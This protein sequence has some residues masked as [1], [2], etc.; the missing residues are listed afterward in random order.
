MTFRAGDILDGRFRL[1]KQLGAGSFGTVFAATQLV[2]GHPFRRVAVKI[3]M[4][5][6]AVTTTPHEE[7]R[8]AERFKDVL[9]LGRVLADAGGK[10][11][12]QN[13][14]EIY[15]LF[16]PKGNPCNPVIV[17]ELVEGTTLLGVMSQA[18]QREGM[19]TEALLHYMLPIC[20]AIEFMHTHNPHNAVLHLDLKP[21]NILVTDE[22]HIKIADFG[23]ATD[24]TEIYAEQPRAG[25][26]AYQAP[27][28]LA[29]M[30]HHEVY[31]PRVDVYA[32]G[33]IMYQMLTGDLPR[34][35]P[36]SA[37][38]DEV[39]LEETTD[40]LWS[41]S[42]S[43]PRV[44]Q[45]PN[46]PVLSAS[47]NQPLVDIVAKS[48][49]FQPQQ[50]YAHAGELR[51]ALQQFQSGQLRPDPIITSSRDEFE[52][53]IHTGDYHLQRARTEQAR[54]A[55]RRAIALRPQETIGHI[56]LAET[57]LLEKNPN[58]AIKVLKPCM[59]PDQSDPDVYLTMARA[60][61]DLGN[62]PIATT[63]RDK[64]REL[65]KRGPN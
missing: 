4:E 21:D 15:D 26:I 8:F 55:F 56:R 61:D 60:C 44:D 29:A 14:V 2:V 57:Y 7:T 49:A 54:E 51:A 20:R 34:R 9:T 40:Q 11:V 10:H 22:D 58:E 3:L 53:E 47:E 41:A 62:S 52:T 5:G 65:A 36:R 30:Q 24:L 45:H 31:T 42:Q 33:L 50:R 19:P 64:A 25:A 39:P 27:E 28:V 16:V 23:L 35:L 12:R 18:G 1:E 43:I 32:L 13:F 38:E 6:D 63:L 48:L 17:M 37:S 59:S 46:C